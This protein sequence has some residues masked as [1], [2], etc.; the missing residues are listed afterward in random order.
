MWGTG[1]PEGACLGNNDED[2]REEPDIITALD[3]LGV[4]KISCGRYHTLALTFNGRLFS[5][6]SSEFGWN[7]L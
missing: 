2:G 6:G 5:W 7:I 3:D 1:R 4:E